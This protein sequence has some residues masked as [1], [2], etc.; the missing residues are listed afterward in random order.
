[1]QQRCLLEHKH[2]RSQLA[3]DTM[4]PDGVKQDGL[5]CARLRLLLALSLL[6]CQML[7]ID[8]CWNAPSREQRSQERSVHHACQRLSFAFAGIASWPGHAGSRTARSC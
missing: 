6:R 7:Q 8:A 3:Q 1:M 2:A 5:P 4:M